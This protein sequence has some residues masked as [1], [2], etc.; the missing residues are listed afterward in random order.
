MKLAAVLPRRFRRD[1]DDSTTEEAKSPTRGLAVQAIRRNLL[2]SSD[3]TWAWYQMGTVQ[4]DF[5]SI[6]DR[7]AI[8]G[9]VAL[10]WSDLAG[11]R[12]HMR[13]TSQPVSHRT[14]AEKLDRATAK[15]RPADVP[16]A[17]TFADRLVAA[18]ERIRDLR[19]E[20]PSVYIGV[21]ITQK[22]LTPEELD[23]VADRWAAATPALEKIRARVTRITES[24]AKEGFKAKPVTAQNLGWLLHSSVGLGLPVSPNLLASRDQEWTGGDLDVFSGTTHVTATPFAKTIQVRA[25]RDGTEHSHHAALLSVSRFAERD[26]ENPAI[27]PWLSFT[28]GLPFPV[29]WSLIIDV[30]SGSDMAKRAEF[31]RRRAESLEE[32][33]EE[34]HE[35]PPAQVDRAIDDAS[36]VEDEVTTGTRDIAVRLLTSI[37]C[38]VFGDTEEEALS[39]VGDL[40]EAYANDQRIEV[41]HTYG[42]YDLYREFIPGESSTA[43]GSHLR[44]MPGTFAATAVPNSSSGLGDNEGP[45]LGPVISGSRRALMFNPNWGPQNNKPGLSVIAATLGMGKS[46]LAGVI[47]EDAV[48]AGKQVVISDPAGSMAALCNVPHLAPYAQHIDLTGAEA[49]TLNP[50]LLV[51]DPRLEDFKGEGEWKVAMREAAAERTDLAADA[52]TMLLPTQVVVNDHGTVAVLERAITQVGGAYGTNPWRVIRMLEAMGEVGQACAEKLRAAAPMKGGVLIFPDDQ[53]SQ[54][55]SGT[56]FETSALLTV[57]TSRGSV[58]PTTERREDWT[59]QERMSV[60]VMSLA[61]RYAARAM[62]ANN[63]P[64]VV[65]VDETFISAAGGSFK[66]FIL[67]GSRDS[68]KTNTFFAILMQNPTDKDLIGK[69]IVNLTGTAFVGGMAS[70]ESARG[71][72]SL[73]GVPLGCGYERVM[74]GLEPGQFVFR[75]YLGRVGL[76]HVDLEHRSQE[77]IDALNTTPPAPS[78]EDAFESTEPYELGVFA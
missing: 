28:Q 14:W 10:R 44:V 78:P 46:T 17:Q 9:L 47:V 48:D 62:Y 43:S 7:E 38:A 74:L 50:W 20:N 52:L 39:L 36:R 22:R 8:L 42:Q 60:L 13:I 51:P 27:A 59:R 4:W 26:T 56:R 1:A 6:G 2:V 54:V 45:Y 30:L 29:E 57:L 12:V 15:S 35:T 64:K 5:R 75:D 24:V 67:R 37:R 76:I 77:T 11:H 53:T 40:V 65:I 71:A 72:L 31:D 41:V 70:E 19:L 66:S 21:R 32:H 33:Y 63:A 23:I 55:V 34:H 3:G 18:Q 68:R 16:D 25:L 69:E 61:G 58:M 49:G 73:L